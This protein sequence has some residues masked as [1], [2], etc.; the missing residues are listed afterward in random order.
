MF[1]VSP[2]K[3]HYNPVFYLSQA[4]SFIFFLF[5]P[6]LQDIQIGINI[7]KETP[8]KDAFSPCSG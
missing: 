4:L 8:F 1:T 3:M 5:L 6:F 2:Y 7:K